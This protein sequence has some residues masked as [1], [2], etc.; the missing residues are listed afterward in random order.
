M[1]NLLEEL[2]QYEDLIRLRE[3]LNKELSSLSGTISR[4]N[5]DSI[6]KINEI[7]RKLNEVNSKISSYDKDK[8]DKVNRYF[9]INKEFNRI[10][11]EL[12]TI[13]NLSKDNK[14]EKVEV[15]SAEGRPKRI[16]KSL[17]EE[18]KQLVEQKNS[19]RKKF[20]SEYK[21]IENITT[22]VNASAKINEEVKTA[23]KNAEYI[24]PTFKGY[25]D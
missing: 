8:L 13:E 7:G 6:D 15:K 9:T 18:Y 16:Y 3:N 20:Y 5:K 4:D 24:L 25:E 23:T 22:T 17:V 14:E 1:D 12:K 21:D 19:M 10:S 2:I 11:D